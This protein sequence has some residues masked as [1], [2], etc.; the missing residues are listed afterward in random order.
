MTIAQL[1]KVIEDAPDNTKI[2][3]SA[4]DHSYREARAVITTAF[5][6]RKYGWSEDVGEPESDSDKRRTALIIE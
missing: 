4:S 6:N 3:V 1:K 2:L 5:Y